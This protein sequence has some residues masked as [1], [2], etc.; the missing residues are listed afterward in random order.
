TKVSGKGS[1]A[2]FAINDP[3]VCKRSL[4]SNEFSKHFTGI[5]L[6]LTPTSQFEAK[7][8]Q[9]QMKFTQLWSSMKGLKAGL[10]KLIALSLVLQL[11]ALMTPYYM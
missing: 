9:A 1:K 8:E 4:N 6:E 2:K 11:F 10:I 5:C 7:Q 3:S